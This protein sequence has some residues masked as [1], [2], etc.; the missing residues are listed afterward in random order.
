MMTEKEAH[1]SDDSFK[2]NG[3][4]YDE[5]LTKYANANADSDHGNGHGVQM[6]TGHGWG[7]G[8]KEDIKRTIGTHW[9]RE[10]VN[11]N[12]KVRSTRHWPL[13]L[14]PACHHSMMMLFHS[15]HTHPSAY[16]T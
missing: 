13:T 11:L 16:H 8:I 12:S 1:N 15:S 2:E 6:R 7:R 9:K 4:A 5:V 14:L 3:D 10:M